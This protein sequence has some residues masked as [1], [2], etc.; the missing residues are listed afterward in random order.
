MRYSGI[1][2]II[3]RKGCLSRR[4]TLNRKG[5]DE[6]LQMGFVSKYDVNVGQKK[7]FYEVIDSLSNSGR[8]SLMKEPTF[9]VSSE[10]KN[11]LIHFQITCKVIPYEKKNKGII[12]ASVIIVSLA[13]CPVLSVRKN[14]T[15]KQH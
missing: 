10:A 1:W 9:S 2:A 8:L 7:I 5:R 13:A 6:I 11:S 12:Y 14:R 3:F 15:D 4:S